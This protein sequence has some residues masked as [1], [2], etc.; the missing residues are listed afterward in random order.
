M[1]Y[2]EKTMM[3]GET[4]YYKTKLHWTTFFWPLVFCWLIV[5]LPIAVVNYFSSEF[6]VTNKRIV[7]KTGFI[8]RKTLELLLKNT[9]SINVE[10]GYFGRMLNFGT[11][12]ITGTGGTL[13][14]YNKIP[15]PLT[16]RWKVQEQIDAVK[17]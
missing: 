12:R 13:H 15:S 4:V 8:R 3:D 1:G 6:G 10:Q 14:P 17:K 7:M 9:E 11:V 5:P 2:I 16:F